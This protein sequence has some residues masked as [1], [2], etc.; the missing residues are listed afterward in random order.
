MQEEGHRETTD[1]SH[2]GVEEAA[3]YGLLVALAEEALPA[4]GALVPV[5]ILALGKY[6]SCC[7]LMLDLTVHV[8]S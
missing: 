5:K 4:V 3:T 7:V 2:E 6:C 1:V 8:F